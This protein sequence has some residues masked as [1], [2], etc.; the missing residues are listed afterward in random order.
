[1]ALPDW[2]KVDL[3]RFRQGGFSRTLMMGVDA[4]NNVVPLATTS[5]GGGGGGGGTAAPTLPVQTYPGQALA[6]TSGDNTLTPP[7]GATHALVTVTS[8]TVRMSLGGSAAQ[9]P[10]Y[11][12]D[13]TLSLSGVQLTG[14]HLTSADGAQVW[15]D[16]WRE[17]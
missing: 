16:Y 7:S 3:N 8:G 11:P 6:V 5:L 10:L 9:A 14:L 13:T 1:M 2:F 15:V 17:Q 4:D 12:T